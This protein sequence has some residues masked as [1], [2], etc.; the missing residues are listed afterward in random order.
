[1]ARALQHQNPVGER[2]AKRGSGRKE[3]TMGIGERGDN[4]VVN[5][6]AKQV[7]G[8]VNEVA[9]AASGDLGQELKGKLEKNVGKVQVGVGRSE[10]KAAK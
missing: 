3:N 1:V 5:G 6:A 10:Q 9:G 2:R 7:E 8:K 4:N